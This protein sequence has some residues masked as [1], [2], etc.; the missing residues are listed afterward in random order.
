MIIVPDL[1]IRVNEEMHAWL[2]TESSD[3]MYR[4]MRWSTKPA[5]AR[6]MQIRSKRLEEARE[7]IEV[8]HTVNFYRLPI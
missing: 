3:R 5:N 7:G 2:K 8:R 4:L 6:K 1:K